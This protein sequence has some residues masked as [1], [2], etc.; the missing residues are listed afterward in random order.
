MRETTIAEQIENYVLMMA[1]SG[2]DILRIIVS[3]HGYLELKRDADH[4]LHRASM[5]APDTFMGL[6]VIV[7]NFQREKW[8]VVCGSK[9]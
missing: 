4:K 5:N 6:P 2:A 8:T 9:G 3:A 1:Y 7:D